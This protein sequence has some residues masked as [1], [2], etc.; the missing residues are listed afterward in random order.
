MI[1]GEGT[2]LTGLGIAVGVAGALGLSGVMR[3][4]L[5]EVDPTDPT[6]Y[7]SVVVLL[8]LIA[9]MA[10]GLPALRAARVDPASTM[11]TE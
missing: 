6:T 3:S 2:L 10:S 1:V 7:L 8:G 5:F 4:L 11:R 9:L